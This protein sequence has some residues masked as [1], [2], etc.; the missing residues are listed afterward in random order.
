MVDD[1][2]KQKPA[3]SFRNI[4]LTNKN[5][6]RTLTLHAVVLHPLTLPKGL[7]CAT[8]STDV[9]F[10]AAFRYIALRIQPLHWAFKL[11]LN[12]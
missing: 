9:I 12:Q 11:S 8:G 6:Q 2:E 10:P 3:C 4:A 7:S 5:C 1:L